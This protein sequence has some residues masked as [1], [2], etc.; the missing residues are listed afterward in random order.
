[1]SAAP[2]PKA[3][4]KSA[5][6][7]EKFA[8]QYHSVERIEFVKWLPCIVTL[9]SP[10][11]NVHTETGGMGRKADYTTIV[12]MISEKHHELHDIG[13]ET[14]LR[15]YPHVNLRRSAAETEQKWLAHQKGETNAA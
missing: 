5:K 15:K 3:P 9:K 2:K 6:E 4:N 14:F 12:P 1:V 11:E 7:R 10:C 13:V 8:R